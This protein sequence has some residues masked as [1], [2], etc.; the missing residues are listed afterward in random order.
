MINRNTGWGQY[1]GKNTQGFEAAQTF[2]T[3]GL[4]DHC[5][6]GRLGFRAIERWWIHSDAFNRVAQY[7]LGEDLGA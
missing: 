5:A 6:Q 1:V 3:D 7:G 4:A 2:F